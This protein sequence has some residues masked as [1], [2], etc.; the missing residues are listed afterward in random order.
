MSYFDQHVKF[1]KALLTVLLFY[2]LGLSVFNLYSTVTSL[3]DQNTFSN[4]FTKVYIC[5]PI[6]GYRLNY[7]TNKETSDTLCPGDM[8]IKVDG[9][10][11]SS[12]PVFQ[13]YV[14][15]TVKPVF[16][17]LSTKSMNL[18]YIRCDISNI[19]FSDYYEFLLSGLMIWNVEQ[20][21]ASDR[22]GIK[23][24]DI[25]TKVNGVDV[26]DADIT[27]KIMRS[28]SN[29]GIINYEILRNNKYINVKVVLATFG[30][31][32]VHL[33]CIF[34]GLLFLIVGYFI[35]LK[36][37]DIKSAR[38]LG[39]A[40]MILSIVWLAK[41]SSGSIYPIFNYINIFTDYTAIYAGFSMLFYST[42]IFPDQSL[43]V[44][45][46]KWIKYV[47]IAITLLLLAANIFFIFFMPNMLFVDWANWYLLSMFVV[48]LSMDFRRKNKLSSEVRKTVRPIRYTYWFIFIGII[49]LYIISSIKAQTIYGI[50]SILLFALI[51]LSYVYGIWKYSL[52]GIVIKIRRNVQYLSFKIIWKIVSV[53][54]IMTL[55]FIYSKLNFTFPNIIITGKSIEFL[56]KPL[57][58]DRAEFYNNLALVLMSLL[59]IYVFFKLDKYLIKFFDKIFHRTLP[60]YKKAAMEILGIIKNS[61]TVEDFSAALV[62]ELNEL[63]KLKTIGVLLFDK[64]FKLCGQAF[65]GVNAVNLSSFC[66]LV[67]EELALEISKYQT[68]IKVDYLNEPLKEVFQ[69][70]HFR[71]LFPIKSKTNII[72]AILVG[73]KLS[74]AP[75]VNDDMQFLSTIADQSSVA[76]ENVLLYD[77]LREQERIKHELEIARKIQLASLPENPPQ[78]KNLDISGMSVP[79]YEVGGDFFDYLSKDDNKVDIIV[80]DVS[81]K[82]TSAALHMSKAQGII[83]TVYEFTDGPK[84]ILVR[85]NDLIQKYLDKNSFI[86]VLA[87]EI[88]TNQKVLKLA[89]AGHNPMYYYNSEKSLVE[90][91]QPKG[92]GLGMAKSKIFSNNLDEIQM[93]IHHGDAFLFISDGVVEARNK[94]REEYNESRLVSAFNENIA[95][96][97]KEIRSRIILDV[98]EFCGNTSQYDD[99]TL[100]IVK[101][102]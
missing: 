87:A 33:V 7:R 70:C 80:G 3:T 77:N 42:L 55:I 90:K 84:N 54:C 89:R 69:Q 16:L 76:I 46:R 60:D 56:D 24:G 52:F 51:P 27:D 30:I 62:K 58:A 18:K 19:K 65:L 79:A 78:I 59:S 8:I 64:Q 22:A 4:L 17:I 66:S 81:G 75:F 6:P 5:R 68:E 1:F 86:S 95:C 47:I 38:L 14:D 50:L 97:A 13:Y 2:I 45:K 85:T 82:G 57:R 73:E 100:V 37:S 9:H 48:R 83:R 88:D 23:A 21:G 15:R 39:S 28:E 49:I 12:E 71:Y 20:K 36:R 43:I 53:S 41:Y 44:G 99:F 25:I 92:I 72:G 26:K 101:V 67:G 40:F 91:V 102:I 34:T 35:G 29:S 32:F 63:I 61:L 74:E 93:P 31:Q 96:P 10:F 94:Q 98:N 11:A